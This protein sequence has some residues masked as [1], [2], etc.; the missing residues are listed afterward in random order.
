VLLFWVCGR[1]WED[2][3]TKITHCGGPAGEFGWVLSYRGLEKALEM[4][5]FLY[6]DPVKNDGRSTHRELR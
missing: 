3:G 5:T 6:R 4:G 2:S 1:I